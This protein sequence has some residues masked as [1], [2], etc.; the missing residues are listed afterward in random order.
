MR[1]IQD[2]RTPELTELIQLAARF[3][4]ESSTV[5][6]HAGIAARFRKAGLRAPTAVWPAEDGAEVV[7]AM[8]AEARVD[9]LLKEGAALKLAV[10][11]VGCKV[12]EETAL[13]LAV[14]VFGS[15][16]LVDVEC[17]VEREDT[18]G[19][20]VATGRPTVEPTPA[21]RRRPEGDTA[22]RATPTPPSRE[23]NV[24]MRILGVGLSPSSSATLYRLANAFS[25]EMW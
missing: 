15:R 8:E 18:P 17:E 16:A 25:A 13:E 9:E 10:T 23:M 5:L 7:I 24:I 22:A 2:E 14:V 1:Q 11:E 19:L 4:H 21:M 3:K 6:R 12:L 20:S